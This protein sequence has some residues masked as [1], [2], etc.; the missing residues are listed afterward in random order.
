MRGVWPRDTRRDVT[1][2]G[3]LAVAGVLF[4]AVA[5]AQGGA[6]LVLETSGVPGVRPYSEL[7]P[8][9][10]VILGSS[11]RLVFLHYATCR[12]VTLEGGRVT[13]AADSYTVAGGAGVRETPTACPRLVTRRSS[14]DVVVGGVVTR[15]LGPTLALPPAPELVLVGARA[16]DYALARIAGE[17][18]EPH[19]VGL[20]GPRLRWPAGVPPL[21]VGGVYELRLV[22][23]R[24]DGRAVTLRFQVTRPQ[25]AQEPIT[26]IHVE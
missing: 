18:G 23:S 21:T 13:L 15:S 14:G 24:G 8:G 12:T 25:A 16:G 10:S 7:R 20:E 17:N 2:I 3:A 11:A 9:A 4:P 22:P 19:E 1:L 6:A 26:V 5:A